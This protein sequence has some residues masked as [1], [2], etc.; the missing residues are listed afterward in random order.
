MATGSIALGQ[1][2]KLA[3]ATESGAYGTPMA[4]G[5]RYAHYYK[6]SLRASKPIETDPVIGSALNNSRDAGA[7]APTLSSHGGTLELPV[8][9]NQIGDWLRLV[10]GA[11]TTS[12]TTNYTHTFASGAV[13]LPTATIELNPVA[14][15]FR[16]HVS[17]G[18]SA[19][20]MSFGD[21]AG[22]QRFQL[23]MLGYD[24][25]LL[26]TTGAGTPTAA[27][28]YDPMAKTKAE[29]LLGGV[30]VGVLLGADM[31]Y[32]TG[33][34]QD[35]YIDG[36][37]G[38]GAAVLAEQAQFSGNLR[39]RYNGNTL[40]TAALNGTE[41]SLELER[42]IRFRFKRRRPCSAVPASRSKALAGSSKRFH[43]VAIKPAARPWFR[44]SSRTKRRPIRHD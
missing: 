24:E 15:D 38:F 21:E 26:G 14:S 30:A 16:Q 33:L 19:L 28:T 13:T 41:Q 44:R 27:K 36:L 42:I 23:D 12:G 32:D 31:T 4:T 3:F 18:V 17:C 22:F 40:D 20:K 43:S 29:V 5:Y 7:I 6:S 9:L 39:I 10:F 35:R 1:L 37:G 8:C 2:A 25:N 34:V 11:P